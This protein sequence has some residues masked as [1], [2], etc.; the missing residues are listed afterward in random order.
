MD[1][2]SG[3]TH[4]LRGRTPSRSRV[5]VAERRKIDVAERRKID[6]EERR[7]IPTAGRGE[8]PVSQR[9]EVPFTQQH[10]QF[11]AGCCSSLLLAD[12]EEE[13]SSG[14]ST[15]TPAGGDDARARYDALLAEQEEL[16]DSGENFGRAEMARLHEAVML[17]RGEAE[18]FSALT[19]EAGGLAH[20]E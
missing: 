11:T 7:K 2:P 16:V 6:V 9:P 5:P 15:P 8:V 4:D 13:F 1:P 17:A 14:S 18:S 3:D 12:S 19:N 20:E 10:Q